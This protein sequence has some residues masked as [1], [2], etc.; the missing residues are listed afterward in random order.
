MRAR[1]SWRRA[2]GAWSGTVKAGIGRG[3]SGA[4]LPPR[5][6]CTPARNGLGWLG[7]SGENSRMDI[8][9]LLAFSVKNKASDLHLSTGPPPMI[10]VDGDVRR[11][12]MP[13]RDHKQAHALV[14]DIM[15]DQQRRCSDAT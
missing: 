10:R 8:A 2:A 15:S 12:N 14:Y 6:H 4:I 9:E 11:S 7:N 13:G 1:T 3:E 5:G